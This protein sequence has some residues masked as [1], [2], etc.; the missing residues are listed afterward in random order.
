M[1]QEAKRAG[2]VCHTV[3]NNLG[4][5]REEVTVAEPAAV[6]H[7]VS[8]YAEGSVANL[9]RASSEARA[10]VVQ[11]DVLKSRPAPVGVCE[12][13]CPVHCTGA[14]DVDPATELKQVR[15]EQKLLQEDRLRFEQERR[16]WLHTVRQESAVEVGAQAVLAVASAVAASCWMTFRY[17]PFSTARCTRD[18]LEAYG[19]CKYAG[20]AEE[21]VNCWAS[22]EGRRRDRSQRSFFVL[23]ALRTD[24]FL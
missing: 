20:Y 10:E 22:A 12:A 11:P 15:N 23:K 4:V 18:E 17:L 1:E 3:Y 24:E 19:T 21:L 5:G 14:G 2:T 13:A 6:S 8:S 16:Q 7:V 9:M